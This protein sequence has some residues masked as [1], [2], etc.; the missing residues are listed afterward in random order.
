MTR[1][2]RSRQSAWLSLASFLLAST[3]LAGAAQAVTITEVQAGF[4][5]VLDLDPA[6]FDAAGPCGSGRSVTGDGCSVVRKSDSGAADAYGRTDPRGGAWIDSQDLAEV[7]WTVSLQRPVT[8]LVLALTDAFD[9][10]ESERWGASRFALTVGE[11]TWSI[12]ERQANSTLHWLVVQFD[13][14]T[15]SAQ[16]RFSTRLNDGW[17]LSAASVEALA[18]VPLPVTGLLLIAGLGGLGLWRR[19][20]RRRSDEG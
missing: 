8:Q 5:Q 9:Q 4:G 7:T 10:G 18:P 2:R 11:A 1:L 17:G 16:L 20:P 13:T 15:T 6:D 12:T 14:P 3:V 19:L